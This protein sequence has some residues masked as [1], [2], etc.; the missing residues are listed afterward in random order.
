[1]PLLQS[2]GCL[3]A[4]VGPG[5]IVNRKPMEQKTYPAVR[6]VRAYVALG[7]HRGSEIQLEGGPAA[8]EQKPPLQTIDTRQWRW[9]AV[10]Q[11]SWKVEEHIDRLEARGYFLM[12]R[13]RSRQT[14]MRHTSFLHLKDSQVSVGTFLKHRSPCYVLNFLTQGAAALELACNF[15]PYPGLV[16]THRNPADTASRSSLQKTLGNPCASQRAEGGG[17]SS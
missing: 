16:R 3:D 5:D 11:T 17:R 12:L 7:G 6:L 15:N 10:V 14:S 9:K 8:T 2:W 1:M 13:W 4:G